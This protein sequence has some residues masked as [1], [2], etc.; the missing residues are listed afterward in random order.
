MSNNVIV[1]GSS[2]IM[3]ENEYGNLIDSFDNVCR[4]NRAPVKNYEKYVGTKTTH[5]FVNS[6]VA[7]NTFK[8][9]DDMK[10]IKKLRNQ[11]VIGDFP[12][13]KNLIDSLYHK[14]CTYKFIDRSISFN[15]IINILG[16]KKNKHSPSIGLKA[17]CY[18]LDSNYDVTIYGFDLN[19]KNYNTA[20]HYFKEKKGIG[21][22]HD[23]KYEREFLQKMLNMNI[24]K[25]LGE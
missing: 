18:F 13:N 17:I 20:P 21:G 11:I 5:R 10:F 25:Y 8:Q 3:L 2:D 4:C 12:L 23:F 16:L 6:H 15:N 24:I 22:S 1:I 14:S 19:N 9:G 7:V